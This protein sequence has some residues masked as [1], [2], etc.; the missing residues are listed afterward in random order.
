MNWMIVEFKGGSLDGKN[1]YVDIDQ[2]LFAHRH[3]P[4]TGN[5]Q[6]AHD[7]IY[8]IRRAPDRAPVAHFVA[9]ARVGSE[10]SCIYRRKGNAAKPYLRRPRSRGKKALAAAAAE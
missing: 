6:W 4:D 7:E 8:A 9:E 2:G 1:L 10:M 5:P 3:C